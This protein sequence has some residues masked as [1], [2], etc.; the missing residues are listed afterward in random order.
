[1][2]RLWRILREAL[3][4]VVVLMIALSS[5]LLVATALPML[6]PVAIIFAVGGMGYLWLTSSG[7]PPRF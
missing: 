7:H 3:S 2:D 4:F 1:M 5:V 6:L